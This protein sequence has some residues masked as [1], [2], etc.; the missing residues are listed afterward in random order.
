MS[1]ADWGLAFLLGLASTPHCAVMCGP[2][3]LAFGGGGGGPGRRSV[4]PH[5]AYQAGRILTYSLLG[6]L[7]GWAGQGALLVGHVA[8]VERAVALAAG[9]LLIG[10]GITM[11]GMVHF[12]RPALIQL[13]APLKQVAPLLASRS[14]TGK[15]GLGLGLGLL[16]CGL[17]W[18]ALAKAGVAATPW[19]GA[20]NMAAFGAGTAV[21]L[22]AIGLFSAGWQRRVSPFGTRLA[23][24]C[25]VV[26]GIV[27][28]WRGMHPAKGGGSVCHVHHRAAS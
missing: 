15:F 19:D 21:S 10:V 14:V 22:L 13:Q 23:A 12:R 18:A 24:V 5:L 20:A 9:V 3:V 6:A 28:I 27:T 1:S 2:I 17:V 4:S 16:P 8:G 11:S 25:M 26:F 7:A